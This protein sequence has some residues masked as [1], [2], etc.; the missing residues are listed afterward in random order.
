M[1]DLVLLVQDQFLR[2]I[3]QRLERLEIVLPVGEQVVIVIFPHD[4][5]L[6]S[7]LLT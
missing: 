1:R 2:D 4:V 7:L 6:L 5:S 3:E